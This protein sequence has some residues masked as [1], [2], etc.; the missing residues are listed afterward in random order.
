M[1]QAVVSEGFIRLGNASGRQDLMERGVA[2]ARASLSLITEERTQAN[3]YPTPNLPVSSGRPHVAE[4]LEPENV[5]HEGLPQLPARSG[6]DWGEVG[7]LA[8]IAFA[9][10]RFGGAFMDATRGLCIGIDGVTLDGCAVLND[11]STITVQLRSLMT[12]DLLTRPWNAT[13]GVTLKVHGLEALKTWRLRVSGRDIAN[14]S[15]ALLQE[16]VEVLV[17]P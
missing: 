13:F 4:F 10:H 1:R 8:A 3:N 12:A 15:S 5:D 6:P 17:T 9:R 7:G 16:G 14:Y 2:A 11:T